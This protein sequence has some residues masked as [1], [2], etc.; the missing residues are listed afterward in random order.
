MILRLAGLEELGN[1]RQTAGDVLRLRGLAR[2]L[3]DD[4]AGVDRLA[5]LR[6]DVRADRQEVARV[7]VACSA[8]SAVSP[9]SGSLMRDARAEIRGARLDDD[10]AREAGDLVEL[11]H[12]VTPS[13]RSPYF[14]MPPTSVRIGVANGSHSATSLPGLT[15][16]PSSHLEHRAV[17]E[18]VVLA[19]AAGVVD[20]DELAVAVH[21]DDRAV[22][23]LRRAL[24]LRK[25]DDAFGARLERALL[26][27]AARRRTT[28]VERAHRELRAR[29]AD[30][31]GGDDADRLADVDAVAARQVAAV[32]HARTRR[33][34]SGR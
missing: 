19:L 6:D 5:F 2:D 30:R 13:T 29:L 10:L 34:A 24:A 26:D 7:E 28:D 3:R 20:D 1:A 17:D 32:A 12:H 11:L 8:A 14:T 25:R 9:V 15:R 21:D 33:D 23:A 18:A 27:L 4:V 31:L 22:L 16:S